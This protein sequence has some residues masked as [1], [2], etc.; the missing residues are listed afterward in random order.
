MLNKDIGTNDKCCEKVA[1]LLYTEGVKFRLQRRK[2]NF[3]I[4]NRTDDWL[5]DSH[6]NDNGYVT[7]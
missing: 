3:K 4:K 2:S 5:L 1:F 6:P 7:N